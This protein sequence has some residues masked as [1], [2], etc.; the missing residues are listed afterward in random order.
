[1]HSTR[2]N[3]DI[4]AHYNQCAAVLEQIRVLQARYQAEKK[5]LPAIQDK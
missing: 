3:V 4:A 5:R 1:M 2:I